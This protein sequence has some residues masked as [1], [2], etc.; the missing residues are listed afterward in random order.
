MRR[1][2]NLS[3]M[4]EQDKAMARDLNETNISNMLDREF[5]AMIIRILTALEKRME[6]MSENLNIEIRNNIMEIKGS[7]NKMRKTLDGMNSRLE[8]A[9][10]QISDPEDRVME[11]NQAEQKRQQ[12]IMQNE[13]GLR[14]RSNSIKCNNIIL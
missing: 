1:Q 5:K 11:S 7:I 4:K 10:E 2:R 9:Q 8:E 13:N 12:K 14:E 6:D 3:Q